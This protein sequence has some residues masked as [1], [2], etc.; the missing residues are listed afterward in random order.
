MKAAEMALLDALNAFYEMLER[1]ENAG[2]RK[3]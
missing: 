1:F 2:L 3:D